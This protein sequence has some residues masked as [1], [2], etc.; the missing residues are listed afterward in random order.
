MITKY[1]EMVDDELDATLELEL[2]NDAKDEIE[3]E[4]IWLQL[5]KEQEYSVTSGLSFGT[6]LGA[7]P[8]RFALDVRM[9]EDESN[10]DYDKVGFD[11]RSQKKYNPTGYFLDINAGN[12]H[13]TG[14]NHSAKTMFLYYTEYSADLT[15]TDTW[16]FPSRFHSLIPLKMAEVYYAADAGEKSRAWDDRWALQYAK[17]FT[18]MTLWN[19]S[20]KTRNRRDTGNIQSGTPKSIRRR[21]R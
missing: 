20:L 11:D 3:S 19:D 7:L 13:L 6:A 16:V 2:L 8:T 17:K 9:T 5:L 21:R 15:S 18:Q 4:Q 10:F 1:R 14:E 12:I